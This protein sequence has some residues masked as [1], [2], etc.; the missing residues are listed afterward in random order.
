LTACLYWSTAVTDAGIEPDFLM[1]SDPELRIPEPI[2]DFNPAM[3]SLW[4]AALERPETDMQRMAAE[5]IARAHQY[6]IPGLIK[7]VP[8][9][10]QI[11]MDDMSNPAA[12]FAAAHALIVLES[13]DS[14]QKLFEASQLFGADLK[15]LV[16]PAVA[17][18]DCAA[19]R[20][21][22]IERLKKPD[23]R[24][25]ELMLA[26]QGLGTVRETLALDDLLSIVEDMTRNPAVR[27]AA[28]TSAGNIAES[29]LEQQADRLARM[30]RTPLFVNQL[31]AVRL[32]A[33]HSGETAR[34][35]LIDLASHDEPVV[36]A[37]AL[38]RLNEIDVS[39]VLPMAES[40][41][42]SPDP[43]VR[44]Q[45]ATAI[46]QKPSAPL[47]EPLSQLLDDPN[48]ELR[49][50]VAEGLF[51]LSEQPELSDLIRSEALQVLT[52]DGWQGQ[53]QAALLIGKL[54]YKAAANRL[55][56]LLKSPRDEVRISSAWAL[57][58]VAVQET[59]PAML[60]HAEQRTEQRRAGSDSPELDQEIAHVFEALGVLQADEATPL[61]LTYVPKRTGWYLSRGAAIW[62]IG[63]LNAGTR[64]QE[65]ESMLSARIR[66]F[67][68]QPN[69][70]SL[71]KRMS[72]I[73]L[74]RM[75]AVEQAS[76]LRQFAVSEDVRIPLAL[77]L[78]WAVRELTGEELP[79]PDPLTIDQGD[80]FLEPLP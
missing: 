53:E 20:T 52:E 46:L 72:A 73:T 63:R 12:R 79:S 1:D 43:Q 33:S 32:L 9:L 64:N 59:V 30:T 34:Q 41:M 67:A 18:W 26:I 8:R 71:V 11:L 60:D 69:E 44:L 31:C 38:R 50:S 4:T 74:G 15:E 57:R 77:A 3:A 61:L 27:L 45:G 42:K 17:A 55:V 40:V 29:G 65:I 2:K 37:A 47:I 58:K 75:Q 39:L 35:S 14:E 62:A 76:M 5:T 24:P 68:P 28:A 56:E 54:E 19:A 51:R 23:T 49:R 78:G 48:P 22:W 7:T 66:D 36:A 13:R 21:T 6:G 80:W 25:R 16:E 70:T 10:E